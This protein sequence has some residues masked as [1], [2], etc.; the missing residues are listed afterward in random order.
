M[1][2]PFLGGHFGPKLI[3]FNCHPLLC[4][5]LI[6]ERANPQL[7]GINNCMQLNKSV[8]FSTFFFFSF[9]HRQSNSCARYAFK[10]P[11]LALALAY[12]HINRNIQ[13]RARTMNMHITKQHNTTT[14]SVGYYHTYT[15]EKIV[16]FITLNIGAFT[17]QPETFTS[18]YSR[19][20]H[21]NSAHLWL[22]APLEVRFCE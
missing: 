4:P 16:A 22:F 15:H 18:Q 7:L 8:N 3:M 21:T 10:W 12:T 5:Q 11:I 14:Q 6:V 9:V 19:V 1:C 17:H 13:T 20:R 2:F